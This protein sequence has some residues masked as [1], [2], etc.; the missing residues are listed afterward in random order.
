MTS[1][2]DFTLNVSEINKSSQGYDDSAAKEPL[3]FTREEC[4]FLLKNTT[5]MRK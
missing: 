4:I 5:E 2:D 3:V 1:M